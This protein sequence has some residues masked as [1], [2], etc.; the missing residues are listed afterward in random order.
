M[1]ARMLMPQRIGINIGLQLH[2][3][4]LMEK[5]SRKIFKVILSN[6]AVGFGYFSTAG[7]PSAEYD[8][9]IVGGGHNGLVAASY[10]A[11]SGVRTVVLERRHVLGKLVWKW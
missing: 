2:L 4:L 1:P 11:R 5:F 8:A 3:K 7:H 10:L 6:R 9:V